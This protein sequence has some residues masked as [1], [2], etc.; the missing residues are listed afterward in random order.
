[1]NYQVTLGLVR[2][3]PSQEPLLTSHIQSECR[4][5]LF[6]A[7]VTDDGPNR[8]QLAAQVNTADYSNRCITD[9]ARCGFP[10]DHLHAGVPRPGGAQNRSVIPVSSPSRR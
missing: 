7:P 8:I 2:V 4:V 10:S 5:R 6:P 9:H 3:T 1:M